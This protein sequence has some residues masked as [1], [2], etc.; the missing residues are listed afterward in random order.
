MNNSYTSGYSGAR[1]CNSTNKVQYE[2][3][4]F[5][6]SSGFCVAPGTY[7]Q[8]RMA[9]TTVCAPQEYMPAVRTSSLN[10]YNSQ[11]RSVQECMH[12]PSAVNSRKQQSGG[13]QMGN[14]S[15]PRAYGEAPTSNNADFSSGGQYCSAPPKVYLSAPGFEK[16]L[17]PQNIPIQ[18]APLG[19]DPRSMIKPMAPLTVRVQAPADLFAGNSSEPRTIAISPAQLYG[20][21]K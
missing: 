20:P 19:T 21:G 4:M 12:W 10:S 3:Y 15:D 9:A 18:V 16:S 8:Q 13:Y 2:P 1:R 6:G 11:G 14:Y 7:P 17:G 5:G